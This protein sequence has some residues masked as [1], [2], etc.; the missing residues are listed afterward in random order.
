MKF[1]LDVHISYKLANYLIRSGHEAVHVNSLPKKWYTTDS[2]ICSY[3]NENDLIV[4]TKDLDFRNSFFLSQTP[5]KLI[6][7]ALG[8]ISNNQLIDLF[9]ENLSLFDQQFSNSCCLI[10]ITKDQIYAYPQK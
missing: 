8:N 9:G 3:A 7:I 2:D 5:R 6:R 1:L 4:I 10:E